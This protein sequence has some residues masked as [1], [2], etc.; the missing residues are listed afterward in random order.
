[1]SEEAKV[2]ETPET[3]TSASE[4]CPAS[5]SSS[6]V[7]TVRTLQDV[8]REIDAGQLKF[9]E[10]DNEYEEALSLYTAAFLALKKEPNNETLS[11][12]LADAT[13]FVEFTKGPVD[14]TAKLLE[15]L[16][17]ELDRLQ[18]VANQHKSKYCTLLT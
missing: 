12:K 6:A 4:Y 5:G 16:R 15:D 17:A 3:D 7:A 10:A 13:K 8:Q 14:A 1:M 2:S 11:K 18:P 9:D